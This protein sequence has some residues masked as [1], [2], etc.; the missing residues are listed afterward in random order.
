MTTTIENEYLKVNISARGAELTS[1][2]NKADSTEHLWQGNPE[3]WPWHGPNLFPFVGVTMNNQI[4]VDGTRYETQRHGFIRTTDLNLI[5]S[6]NLHAKFSLPYSDETLAVYPFKFEYQVIYDLIDNTLRITYKVINLD[7]KP[8]YFS[9]GAHPGFN[10]PFY[11]GESYNDYYL[12][13]EQEEELLAYTLTTD[14]TLSGQTKP[15]VLNGKKLQLDK[16]LFAKDALVFKDIKSKE[17]TIRSDKHDKYVSVQYPH[18]KH[19]GIWAKYKADFV[20][21]EPWLG[22]A[23]QDGEVIEIKDKPAIMNIDKGHVYEAEHFIS[24]G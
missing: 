12:D 6:N 14:G 21:I 18:F 8:V 4:K 7:E 2:Y 10:V 3:I 16:E 9:V 15:V 22:Y 24:I 23:D 11:P 5:D 17:I 20:C 19:M 1:I 13:F